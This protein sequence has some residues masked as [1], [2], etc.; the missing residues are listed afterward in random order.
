MNSLRYIKSAQAACVALIFGLFMV[1]STAVL[2]QPMAPSKPVEK[3]A[4]GE[5]PPGV[6]QRILSRL[7][8]ARPQLNFSDIEPSPMED[9]YRIK[10][11]G[12]LAFVGRDGGYMIVGEMYEVQ[13]NNLVNLQEQERQ[14]A[15]LAF[16]PK[17][18]QIIS[19]ISKD[20]M[21]IYTPEGEVKGY[22]N[23]FTDIDCGYCRRLHSQ[24]ASFLEKGI[25][26]RYLAFPRA[27]A[28]SQSAQK[29]ATV[30]CSD[31]RQ[32][33][34]TRFK[35]GEQVPIQAC[36]NNPVAD[37]YMLGQEIGVTGTP[38]IVLESGRIIPG[39]VSADYL[40]KEMGI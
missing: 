4:T 16:A 38:A 20:D 1:L 21:V 39:A 22:V 37:Q 13:E 8:K 25:E 23:V 26:I 18:A 10:V 17:R 36:D 27:G 35:K 19:A 33:L 34:L 28:K 15:E 9:V 32:E 24:L 29:L 31:N 2:A 5:V 6:Q 14:A 3:S 7:K 40:A 12:Q 11:N 30:W